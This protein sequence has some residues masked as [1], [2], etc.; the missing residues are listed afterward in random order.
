MKRN[1]FIAT[2]ILYSFFLIFITL[3]V[4]LVM[5]YLHNQVLLS[6]IDEDAWDFLNEIKD[7]K[8]TDLQVGDFVQF[9]NNPAQINQ[10][11][12]ALLNENANWVLAH[13]EDN[14]TTKTMIFLS[15]LEAHESSVKMKLDTDQI[16]KYR[17]AT[18]DLYNGAKSVSKD[19]GIVNLYNNQ[20]LFNSSEANRLDITMVDSSTLMKI[21]NQKDAK[22]EPIDDNILNAI[23]NVAGSYVV[24]IDDDSINANTTSKYEVGAYYE[25][26]AYSFLLGVGH[27]EQFKDYCQVSFD[28][29]TLTYGNNNPFGYANLV[30]QS[31][32]NARYVDYCWYASP[33]SYIHTVD[34][35]VVS[36]NESRPD[37]K[38]TATHS[39][40]YSLRMKATTTLDVNATNTYISAG[41]GLRNDPYIITDGS[42]RL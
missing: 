24:Y 40:L 37:D 3:F 18:I 32:S 17:P 21:R 33:K 22:G 10:D 5:N 6:Q 13:I 30:K 8:I 34:E 12:T 1:G 7:K 15:D 27:T 28:G 35:Y 4:A 23:Y 38:I 42:K 41:K 11:E 29:T 26:R 9:R 25:N 20:V 2:S 39:V 36:N 14:G 19:S 31:L 16:A